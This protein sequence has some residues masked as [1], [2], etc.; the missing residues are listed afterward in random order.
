MLRLMRLAT[1]FVATLRFL[2]AASSAILALRLLRPLLRLTL[3]E[4]WTRFL[5]LSVS[6]VLTVRGSLLRPVWLS[7]WSVPTERP[8]LSWPLYSL[9]FPSQCLLHLRAPLRRASCGL[10]ERMPPSS[11]LRSRVHISALHWWLAVE[12]AR[13]SRSHDT[14][15]AKH[16]GSRRGRDFRTAVVNGSALIRITSSASLLL[17]LLSNGSESPLASCS[18]LLIRR[19]GDDSALSAVVTDLAVVIYDHSLVVNVGDVHNVDVIHVAIVIEI[20]TAPVTTVI[21]LAGIA[22]SVVNS[23]IEPDRGTPVT[24]IPDKRRVDRAPSPIARRPQ[25]ALVRRR[26]P[27]T[28]NP[29][30]PVARVPGPIARRPEIA[31]TGAHRLGIIR[32]RRRAERHHDCDRWRIGRS[33]LNRREQHPDSNDKRKRREQARALFRPHAPP[34]ARC[35]GIGLRIVCCWIRPSRIVKIE[36]SS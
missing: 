8:V 29:V 1:T 31:R 3:L 24:R 22:I 12:A 19:T 13:P 5:L 27:S 2:L 15:T 26:H 20:P 6:V 9:A 32:E 11:P 14:L 10:V 17:H 16:T 25:S 33:L 34:A 30:V 35:R 4:R 28:G 21:A 7:L 36:V 23:A 18:Q